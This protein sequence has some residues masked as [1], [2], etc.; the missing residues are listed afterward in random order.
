MPA[1]KSRDFD[2]ERAVSVYVPVKVEMSS[3]IPQM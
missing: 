3:S 2:Q 1:K